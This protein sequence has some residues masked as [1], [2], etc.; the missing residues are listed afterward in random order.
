MKN[1][2]GWFLLFG[3]LYIFTAGVQMI[4]ELVSTEISIVQFII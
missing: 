4:P 1:K 3:L 2:N